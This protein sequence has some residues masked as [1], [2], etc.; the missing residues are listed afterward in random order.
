M[1][2][3]LKKLFRQT[4]IEPAKS[5]SAP[6]GVIAR[7]MTDFVIITL[8]HTGGDSYHITTTGKIGKTP[9]GIY[10]HGEARARNYFDSVCAMYS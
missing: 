6:R 9:A 5:L 8:I 7:K 1:I 3:F 10:R 2:K 4:P